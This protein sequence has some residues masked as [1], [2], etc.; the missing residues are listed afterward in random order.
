MNRSLRK[1]GRWNEEVGVNGWL[2]RACSWKVEMVG[3]LVCRSFARFV[4]CLLFDGGTE[5]E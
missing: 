4:S 1:E 2:D 5:T 3:L